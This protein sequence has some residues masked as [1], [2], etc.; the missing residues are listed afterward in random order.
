MSTL[1][2]EPTTPS[3]STPHFI[4]DVV[5]D[6]PTPCATCRVLI[7]KGER[8]EQWGD[9]FVRHYGCRP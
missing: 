2:H 6:E 3:P 7:C 5:I 1:D 8:A 4:G 9:W